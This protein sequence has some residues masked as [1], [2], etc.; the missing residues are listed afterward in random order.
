[1]KTVKIVIISLL[2]LVSAFAFAACGIL[3]DMLFGSEDKNVDD[4]NNDHK[5][6]ESQGDTDVGGGFTFSDSH[7]IVEFKSETHVYDKGLGYGD[8]IIMT[9]LNDGVNFFGLIGGGINENDYIGAADGEYYRL[10]IYGDYFEDLSLG[11]YNYYFLATDEL[12]KQNAKLLTINVTTSACDVKGVKLSYDIDCPAVYVVWKGGCGYAHDIILDGKVIGTAAAGEN[13][14]LVQ[15][16]ID[17]SKK[18]NVTVICKE[19]NT[20]VSIEK[21]SPSTYAYAY[22]SADEAFSYMGCTADRYIEDEDEMLFAMNYL[23]YNGNYS[24]T[25][26]DEKPYGVVEMGVCLSEYVRSNINDIFDQCNQMMD[27]PWNCSVRYSSNACGDGV[28]GM[29]SIEYSQSTEPATTGYVS[30]SILPEGASRAVAVNTRSSDCEF[31]IDSLRGA[32]VRNSSELVAVIKAGYKPDCYADSYAEAVYNAAKDICR[33]FISDDMSDTEKVKTFYQY[34]AGDIDYD[35]SVLRLYDLKVSIGNAASNSAAATL[36][37]TA[38]IGEGYAFPEAITSK[39][40]SILDS[41]TLKDEYYNEINRYLLSLSAFKVDGVFINK[42]AVCEGISNALV[43]LCGIE[44]IECIQVS[45]VGVSNVGNATSN[46]SHAWNKVKIGAEWYVVD[47]TWGNCSYNGVRYINH[48][49]L[50]SSEADVS[51]SHQEK[52]GGL[53]CIGVLALGEYNY[54]ADTATIG[55]YDLEID[56]DEELFAMVDWYLGRGITVLEFC[57]GST[58]TVSQGNV[59]NQDNRFNDVVVYAH[60]EYGTLLSVSYSSGRVWIIKLTLEE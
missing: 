52:V 17:K 9:K 29:L 44:G 55:E 23:A 59:N 11:D 22:L 46:V 2:I 8:Y 18:H 5:T 38:I 4:G 51:D 6:Y 33:R 35:D 1:M 53:Y 43:V 27:N 42:L 30:A 3:R 19:D 7:A 20:I 12:G 45:G 13:K 41:N 36:I 40:Q 60:N 49:F 24:L 21:K 57:T 15:S 47:A 16:E 32:P 25:Y 26:T 28:T 58:Y 14:Y 39:L 48:S 37:N 54:Y 56:S 10:T 31:A 34:L 50:L